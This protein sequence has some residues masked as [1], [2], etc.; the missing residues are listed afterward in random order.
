MTTTLVFFLEEPSAKAFL[1]GFLPRVIPG[2]PCLFRSFEGKQELRKEIPRQLKAW[3]TPGCRFVVLH[4]LDAWPD[5]R[6]LKR[7]LV[8]LCT[9]A[10]RDDTLVRIACHELES[11]YLGDLAGVE[12]ALGLP[13]LARQQEKAKYRDPDARPNPKRELKVISGGLYKEI[14]GSRAIGLMLEI[15][16]NRSASLSAFVEGVRRLAETD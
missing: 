14:A 12:R 15:D 13:G 2:V 6:V 10:G 8:T 4:D 5:C 9:E 11:W 7:G 3:R 1:K 16:G